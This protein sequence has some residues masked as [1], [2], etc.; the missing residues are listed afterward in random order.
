[1]TKRITY[2]IFTQHS[3]LLTQ[4]YYVICRQYG[5]QIATQISFRLIT[6]YEFI[7]RKNKQSQNLLKSVLLAHTHTYRGMQ[8]SFFLCALTISIITKKSLKQLYYYVLIVRMS[9]VRTGW[10]ASWLNNNQYEYFYFIF[11]LFFIYV[12][13]LDTLPSLILSDIYPSIH[14]Y[15]KS[16]I[17]PSVRPYTVINKTTVA[18]FT[19]QSK[20]IVSLFIFFFHSSLNCVHSTCG[21]VRDGLKLIIIWIIEIFMKGS[22]VCQSLY[23]LLYTKSFIQLSD[24]QK[25]QKKNKILNRLICILM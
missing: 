4:L 18:T 1:M 21:I 7:T 13:I 10:L 3:S 9:C 17:H 11:F 24:E 25:I 2:L 16:A 14:L 5:T 12:C 22:Q 8:F 15:N 19:Y 20:R 23:P 6:D